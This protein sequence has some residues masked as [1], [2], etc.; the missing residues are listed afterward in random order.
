VPIAAKLDRAAI[1]V[2]PVVRSVETVPLA[3]PRVVAAERPRLLP[4]ANGPPIA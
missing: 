4:F 3:E 2:L 1:V